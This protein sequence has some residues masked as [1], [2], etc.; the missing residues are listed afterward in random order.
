MYERIQKI[1]N[2]LKKE[3]E[4]KEIYLNEEINN[5]FKIFKNWLLENGAIFDNIIEFPVIN[6]HLL[7]IGCKSKENI[8]ENESF[9]MIPKNLIIIS[10]DLEYLEK[11][12]EEIKEEISEK[13]LPILCLALY[14]YLEKKDEN[15]F[16]K[17]Y[18]DIIFIEKENI[19]DLLNKDN[20]NKLNDDLAVKSIE[21]MFNN[22]N[23]IYELIKQCKKFSGIKKEEFIE[24]YIKVISRKIKLNN[25]YALVPLVDLFYSDNSINLKYEIYDSE[26]MIFKYT[27]NIN[28]KSNL[29]NNLYMTKAKYS[30]PYNKVSYNKLIPFKVEYNDEEEEEEEEENQKKI[31]INN[32]DYFS[33]AVSKNNKI[34]KNNIICNNNDLCNK[35]LLKYKGYCLL[36]NKNDYLVIKISFKRGDILIDRYL[37]NIFKENYET[38]NDDPI[39][40]DIKIKIYFNY[41]SSDLL[42][43]FRF[44]YF[45]ELEKDAKK[46]FKYKYNLDIEISIITSSIKFLES[47]L[48][49]MEDNF[50]FENDFKCLENEIFNNNGQKNC[51]K[52]NIIIFRLSQKIIIKNQ[53]N[54]L[55][56]I[57]NIMKKYKIN[58]YNDIYDYINI[59]KIIND[60]DTKENTKLKLLRFIA[61]M[62]ENIDLKNK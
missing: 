25:D 55:S 29:K 12:I 5:K 59:E 49:S 23:D 13:D 40:N 60:Y 22:I 7:K 8:N 31:Q 42:K 62:T 58:G 36:Y 27:S 45:Y 41:I 17:P 47:K 48:K 26:N 39:N 50:A 16:Y 52:E 46:Y 15:S 21:K 10:N 54:L 24:C 44:L 43:Y 3:K 32:N 35:K 53:I 34:L 56:Y 9:L 61:Y 6:N 19:F 30:L 28:N 1:G 14:L 2:Y 33:V 18:I 57:L 37:E 20:L 38:K 4:N 51:L 11:C